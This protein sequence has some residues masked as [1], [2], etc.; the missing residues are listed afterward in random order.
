MKVFGNLIITTIISFWL[1]VLPVFAIQ[2]VV[3]VN[4]K[5]F[6]FESISIPLG[7]LFC[8]CLVAGLFIGA[9]I[10]AFFKKTKK[11][12]TKKPKKSAKKDKSESFVRDWENEEKDPIFDWE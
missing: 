8:F 11:P 7:I 3:G 1:I 2:N 9:F 12:K 4:L 6:F 10:P 5:F